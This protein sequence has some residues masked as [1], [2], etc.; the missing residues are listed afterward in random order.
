MA[1]LTSSSG[2]FSKEMLKI[3]EKGEKKST[4][5]NSTGG[6]KSKTTNSTKKSTKK[7]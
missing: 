4:N 3:L 7:K 6:A 2:Y 5:S 1:K